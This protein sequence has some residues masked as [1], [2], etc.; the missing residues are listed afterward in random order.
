M[1]DAPATHT[2]W[3]SILLP[4]VLGDPD[5]AIQALDTLEESDLTTD[6]RL[7]AIAARALA[8]MGA[9]EPSM[10]AME[11]ALA[12][13]SPEAIGLAVH[14]HPDGVRIGR[15]RLGDLEAGMAADA[16]ADLAAR[17]F[18]EG[19]EAA[20]SEAICHGLLACPNHGELG[21]WRRLLTQAPMDLITL[22]AA[23]LRRG[24]PLPQR[25]DWPGRDPATWSAD[26]SW[27]RLGADL[28]A[29]L[30]SAATGWLPPERIQRKLVPGTL[31]RPLPRSTALGRLLDAGC[32]RCHL[33]TETDY[34]KPH[35][36]DDYEELEYHA[37]RVESLLE[38]GRPAIATA[39]HLWARAR[40]LPESFQEN[41]ASFLACMGILHP[42]LLDLGLQAVR[43]ILRHNRY[44]RMARTREP[45]KDHWMALYAR[46]LAEGGRHTEAR[47]RARR[48]LESGP[49]LPE[50]RALAWET[51][52]RAGDTEATPVR[53]AAAPAPAGW[54]LAMGA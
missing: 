44:R 45:R 30:P 18:A 6:G 42:E 50:T 34:Q 23:N 33:A 25:T 27:A 51:L 48:I 36:R 29:L 26:F 54:E 21:R 41:C 39:H 32:P 15:S 22:A 19:H 2:P 13:A 47:L 11:R 40:E 10:R 5:G 12:D 35:L 16:A 1:T 38:E 9:T 43:T 20:G 24:Q 8:A 28:L 17:C 46:L 7:L 49:V 37:D 3:Q 14:L 31:D 52:Q 4:A 53:R